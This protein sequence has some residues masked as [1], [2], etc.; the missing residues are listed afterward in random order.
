MNICTVPEAREQVLSAVRP[1]TARK[2]SLASALGCVLA[3]DMVAPISL[4]GWDNSAVDGYA[5]RAADVSS[6]G[7][8]NSIH[9]R[10]AGEIPAGRPPSV[11]IEPQTC[12]R[13]FTGAPIP[14][15]ADAVVMQEQT[16]PHT[17]GYVAV[18]E[19]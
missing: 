2:E 19:A 16:R 3:A 18:L 6:A 9:L 4:P 13:I 8:N 10:V 5:L 1:L 15:G 14:D 12:G 11:R 7:E 17:E